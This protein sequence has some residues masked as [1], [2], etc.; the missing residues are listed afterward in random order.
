MLLD[1]MTLAHAVQALSSIR[2]KS[3]KQLIIDQQQYEEWQRHANFEA[4][5]GKK[6]AESFCDYFDIIDYIMIYTARDKTDEYIRKN[7]VR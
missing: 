6:V 7:Y 1:P 4:L 3:G 2:V 5:K